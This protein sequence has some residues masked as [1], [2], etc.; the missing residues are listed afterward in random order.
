MRRTRGPLRV[1]REGELAE[2]P[3]PGS[4]RVEEPHLGFQVTRLAGLKLAKLS[5][6]L[7]LL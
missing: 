5:K 6:I 2:T 4:L 1:L 7:F 3:P